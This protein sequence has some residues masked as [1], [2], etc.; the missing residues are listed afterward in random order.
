MRAGELNRRIKLL[1][2]TTAKD[3]Y[4]EEIETFAEVAEVWAKDEPLSLRGMASA[5][6]SI[7]GGAETA[8]GMRYITIRLRQDVTA[9]WRLQ[10]VTGRLAG[11]QLEIRDVRDLGNNQALVL[12][13]Q[14]LDG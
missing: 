13:A 14:V 10:F 8:S 11:R 9:K 7:L 5:K 12:I 4:G 6:E 2:P 1:A 3:S